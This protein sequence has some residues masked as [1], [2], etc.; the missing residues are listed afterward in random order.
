MIPNKTNISSVK[1]GM[2]RSRSLYLQEGNAYT[3]MFNGQ[4]QDE[5]GNEITVSNEHSN[6]LAYKFDAGYRV[7]G[8]KNQVLKNK[9]YY[10]LTNPNTGCSE[11][12]CVENIDYDDNVVDVQGVD[13]CDDC[14][15]IAE[16]AT[17]LEEQTQTAYQTY[18][19][20]LDDCCSDCGSDPNPKCLGFNVD[21]PIRDIIIKTENVGDVIY[22]TDNNNPPRYLELDD[23]QQYKEVGENCTDATLPC[24][25]V[26]CDKLRIFPLYKN[27]K[28]DD[29]SRILGG[30]LTEGLYEHFFAYC[31]VLGN[32]LTDY[33]SI[34]S[35]VAIFDTNDLIKENR[36]ATRATNYGI[37]IELSEID[38][39]FEYYKIVSSYRTSQTVNDGVATIYTISINPTS[40]NTVI[41][42]RVPLEGDMTQQRLNLKRRNVKNWGGM[43]SANETLFGY[44]IEEYETLNLQPVVNLMGSALQWQTA[45]AREDLYTK[46]ESDR[47]KGYNRDEVVPFG[48]KFLS[49]DG[50]DYPI[51]PLIPKPA[52]AE[53][54][55]DVDTTSNDY[56]SITNVADACD[57]QTRTKS[58]QFYNNATVEGD[59]C[60]FGSLPTTIAKDRIVEYTEVQL[61]PITSNTLVIELDPTETFPGLLE[62][63]NDNVDECE[64][65]T[66]DEIG[67]DIAAPC[68]TPIEAISFSANLPAPGTTFC[69]LFDLD[70]INI[71][72][73]GEVNNIPEVPTNCGSFSDTPVSE[74]LKIDSVLGED[75]TNI[76]TE[77]YELDGMG[78]IIIENGF[79][80]INNEYVLVP[81]PLYC[82]AFTGGGI[83][84]NDEVLDLAFSFTNNFKMRKGNSFFSSNRHEAWVRERYPISN[85]RCANPTPLQKVATSDI[86]EVNISPYHLYYH[87]AATAAELYDTSFAH[88]LEKNVTGFEASLVA[89]A[90][91]IDSGPFW[92]INSINDGDLGATVFYPYRHEGAAWF[93]TTVDGRDEFLLEITSDTSCDN[94]EFYNSSEIR[95]SIFDKCSD[96]CPFYSEIIDLEGHNFIVIDQTIIS[97]LSGNTFYISVEPPLIATIGYGDD[98]T[99]DVED[100]IFD[101]G[102]T[103]RIALV[104]GI[105]D[106]DLDSFIE[107]RVC[108]APPCCFALVDR[109]KQIDSIIAKFDL[110]N[111]YKLQRWETDCDIEVPIIDDCD[112]VPYQK[113]EF[114]HY[115]STETYPCNKE[116]YD[117]SELSISSDDLSDPVFKAKFESYYT[118]GSSGG[119]YSLTDS[120]DFRDQ[121]IRHYR[122]PDNK[123]TP[124]VF[125]DQPSQNNDVIIAPLG[126][127]LDNTTVNDFLDIAVKNNLISQE[128]RDN[129]VGYEMYHGDLRIDRSIQASGL[130]FD[131]KTANKNGEAFR[132]SNYPFNTNGSDKLHED[133]TVQNGQNYMWTFHSPETDYSNPPI[134]SEMVIQGYQN[135]YSR[136]YFDEVRDHSG[137][138]VLGTKAKNLAGTL[139]AL[140]VA[141]DIALTLL[142][143]VEAYRVQIGV[144]NSAN[145]VGIGF[146]IA[147]VAINTINGIVFNY[148]RYRYQWLDTFTNFGAPQN[149][150]YYYSAVGKY[151]SLDEEILLDGDRVRA[152]SIRKYLKPGIISTIDSYTSEKH[153]I[154]HFQREDAVFLSSGNTYP[155]EYP[156]AYYN[157]DNNDNAGFLSSQPIA[158]ELQCRKGISD[159]FVRRIA[160]PYVA[161]KQY[162]SNQHKTINSINWINTGYRSTLS[163]DNT[164]D[165]I[166]GG[167]TYIGRHSVKRKMPLFRDN[168]HKIADNVP[169]EYDRYF[170]L[171]EPR[172]YVNFREEGEFGRGGKFFPDIDNTL[173]TDCVQRRNSFYIKPPEKFYLYY[174]GTPC[175]FAE[176]RIRT[177]FRHASP[178]PETQYY[179]QNTDFMELTQESVV[180]IKE[181]NR[182]LYDVVFSAQATNLGTLTLP[183]YYEKTLY[184]RLADNQNTVMFSQTDRN[185]NSI[186]DPYR[187]FRPLDAATF[188][189][190][191][192]K[193]TALKGIE[194]EQL[195][196]VFE[197]QVEVY[198][199]VELFTSDATTVNNAELGGTGRIFQ[200]PKKTFYDTDLGYMASQTRQILSTEYGH[201]IVD[202][203]RGHIFMLSPGALKPTEISRVNSQGKPSGMAQWFKEHLPFKIQKSFPTFEDVDNAM[204]GVGITMGYDSKYRRIFITKKDYTAAV[205][206]MTYDVETG[207]TYN[208]VVYTLQAAIEAGLLKDVSWTV[209]YKPEYGGWESY[210]SFS[211][212]YYVG[213]NKYFQTGINGTES[214]LWSHLVTN[215]SFGVFYG[216][217]QPWIIEFPTVNDSYTS[218]HLES[219]SLFSE[220]KR[221]HNEYDFAV[222]ERITFNRMTIYSDRENSGLL[223]LV[224]NTGQLSLLSKYP[225]T[226]SDNSQ[227]ILISPNQKR[228]AANYFYNRVISNRNNQPI[229]LWDEN[230][231]L[232]TVND[233]AVS[234]T[235]KKT[236][237]HLTSENFLV[238]LEYDTDSRYDLELKFALDNQQIDDII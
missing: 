111:Y 163:E 159:E 129:I 50:R 185:E 222:D 180:S 103:K 204:N 209:S 123:V 131:M 27:P 24:A 31:D 211:P 147:A 164:C 79:K 166:L 18:T 81:S 43:T 101:E 71:Y 162:I 125:N 136:G 230:Q 121:P 51:Y 173:N 120:A 134:A 9:T 126:V 214:S 228:Y 216:E 28:V 68:D 169:F 156:D 102:E 12:G 86:G 109:D 181:S 221:H 10:F 88:P 30:N 23:I 15:E 64:I 237:E 140:E 92:W 60:A 202:A 82:N 219:I 196:A 70:N 215:K 148:G 85:T 89:L 191:N 26:D 91:D 118:N 77:V 231:I 116:L 97:Q 16:L 3:F 6:V 133:V 105:S 75:L 49:C 213:H 19:T 182:F 143:G 100:V 190:N 61:Q 69:D 74:E 29:Y 17:P 153:Q 175:F 152:L 110:I 62:Y 130:M 32:E 203:K 157:V 46:A 44:D 78:E 146:H 113:G 154:N 33:V 38:Q 40:G 144:A 56:L 22:W 232:K 47:W 235:G 107:V 80:K 142:Q 1:L 7:V 98:Y 165:T 13:Q 52:S 58:W 220:A 20:I 137:W 95:V 115:E 128:D 225:V 104:D 226:N 5:S 161:L 178:Q 21:F 37:R 145:P 83:Q 187:V 139:A 238:R 210:F 205:T 96:D 124:F 195:L 217:K 25:C 193:L 200:R 141:S 87:G 183:D 119:N 155:I 177:E 229:W 197:D 39:S 106:Y 8:K 198:N 233:K 168:A 72:Y 41:N 171:T 99:R 112:P 90:A 117:S 59:A 122:M 158:S 184:Q 167:D 149:L 54:L 35:P 2:S 4:T 236:L 170:N 138:T 94:D 160:S 189:T 188:D 176:T 57:G 42:S 223:N 234:F 135:G 48:I 114:G 55:A 93:S 218:K 108:T 179:P 186:V 67:D 227:D 199:A 206:G 14:T 201:V 132:F 192:G 65:K 73:N 34:T 45:L 208:S 150:A 212:N 11:I 84:E 174:Y 151:S 224:P 53:A 66:A 63:L 172:F 194:N 207:F 76:F 36:E 127:T